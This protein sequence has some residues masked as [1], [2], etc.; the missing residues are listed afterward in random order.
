MATTKIWKVTERLDH[1]IDY[2]SNEE[3]TIDTLLNY[4]ERDAATEDKKYVTSINCS[5]E[6][7]SNSMMALKEM[8]HDKSHIYAYHA[9]QSFKPGEGNPI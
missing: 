8:N 7:P 2:V 1:V 3:K 9:V 6:N 5:I 4:T